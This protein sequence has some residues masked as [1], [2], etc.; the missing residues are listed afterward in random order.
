MSFFNRVSKVVIN[1]V[2]IFF[3]FGLIGVSVAP[4]D[5]E[6]LEAKKKENAW[7]KL[8][9]DETRWADLRSETGQ[10]FKEGDQ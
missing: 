7:K 5:R 9:K 1:P 2:F 10:A 4:S 6:R 3:A 8:S